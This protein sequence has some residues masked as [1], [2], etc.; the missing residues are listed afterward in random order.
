[1]EFHNSIRIPGIPMEFYANFQGIP[2]MKVSLPDG[3]NIRNF[4]VRILFDFSVNLS[5]GFV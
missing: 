3:R 5:C 4:S 1:M 2:K